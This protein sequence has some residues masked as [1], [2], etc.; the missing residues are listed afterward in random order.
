MQAKKLAESWGLYVVLGKNMFNQAN[1]FA[2][3]DKERASDFQKALDN[4]SIKAIWAARGGYGSVRI[5]DQLDFT[6]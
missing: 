6:N 5:L 1:H 4:P 2:G 3:S